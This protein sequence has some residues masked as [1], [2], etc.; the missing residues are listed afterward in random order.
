MNGR[1]CG[2]N[3]YSLAVAANGELSL[4]VDPTGM[5]TRP[6]SCRRREVYF[7]NLR[8]VAPSGTE[9]ERPASVG[10]AFQEGCPKM[11]PRERAG[12]GRSAVYAA[13][14][15]NILVAATKAVAA[16]VTGSSAMLSEAVHSLV[17]TG[18]EVLLLHGMRRSHRRPNRRHPL[19][20]GRE[21]Y[22][23]SF[24]VALLLF[25]AGAGV[26]I[27]QG[28]LHIRAPEPIENVRVSYI[29]LGLSLLFEG[30]SWI[31][32]FRGFRRDKGDLG[33]WAAIR[34]SKNPPQFMVLLE[35]SAAIVGIIVALVGT[36]A[37]VALGD[38]RLDGVASVVIGLLLAAISVVLAR[39]SKGLLIGEQA[40]PELQRTV[41]DIASQTEGIAAANGLITVQLAPDQV[42]V[43]LSLAF[44]RGLDTERVEAIVADMERRLRHVRPE[45]FMLFVKPQSGDMFGEART[46]LFGPAPAAQAGTSPPMSLTDAGAA[47][48]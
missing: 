48:R 39:E 28:I 34:A 3:S 46:R 40:D 27:V 14:I 24:I 2:L 5:R 47:E 20:Y 11:E 17:D 4:E 7:I 21:L 23:W 38:P 45:V 22:F 31:V 32:S 35:D 15:G 26:S 37:S 13:L 10:P 18:N 41:Y 6:K 16:F 44:E 12:S 43:A 9:R 8:E 25:A 1:S 36:W 29:V 30:G 33:Y 42:V 19:G